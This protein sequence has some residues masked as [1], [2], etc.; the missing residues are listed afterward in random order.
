MPIYNPFSSQQDG[1]YGDIYSS[2]ADVYGNSFANPMNPAN[3]NPGFQM[4]PNLLTPSY[5]A[6][7]R[8]RYNGPQP[9]NQYGRVGFFAG[10]NT[11]FNP[12]AYEP[13][14]GN[15][16]DNTT[17]TVEGVSSRPFDS[18]IWAGQRVVAP[19]VG[20]GLAFQYAAKPGAALG[21]AVGRSFGAGVAAGMGGRLARS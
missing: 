5:T 16:I 13:R 2:Q 1:Q 21:R 11:M 6:G 14:W 10:L 12:T 17:Q 18:V 9:Y 19:M 7:Y 3:M 4:D 20:F 8:P 15:P